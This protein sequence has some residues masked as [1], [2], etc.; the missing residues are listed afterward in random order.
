MGNIT[1]Q[2]YKKTLVGIWAQDKRGKDKVTYLL[3][4]PTRLEEKR[5]EIRVKIDSELIR[6]ARLL[7]IALPFEKPT[8]VRHEDY[9]KGEEYIN[10]IPEDMIIHDTVFKKVYPKGIEFIGYKDEIPTA[11]VKTYIKNRALEN[12]IPEIVQALEDVN[13]LGTIK[14]RCLTVQDVIENRRFINM[15]DRK[16]KQDL[17]LWIFET[18]GVKL[19]L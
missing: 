10:N 11:K 16:Q 4:D 13:P 1:I 12:F 14:K 2:Y 5:E 6:I 19:C 8:W 7:N 3:E 9:I 18:M 17:T 15:L